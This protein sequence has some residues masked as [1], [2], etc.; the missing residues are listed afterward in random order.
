MDPWA[1]A[2]RQGIAR[3][4]FRVAIEVFAYALLALVLGFAVT[5]FF[6]SFYEGEPWY[7]SLFYILFQYIVNAV[8]IYMVDEA[9][10]RFF[11]VDADSFVGVSVFTNAFLLVQTQLYHRMA[12]L[13]T[14]ITEDEITRPVEIHR[15]PARTSAVPPARACRAPAEQLEEHEYAFVAR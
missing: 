13:Y 12:S 2:S 5:L 10:L 1:I 14:L 9:Y 6:P 3:P 4:L 15:P 7:L 8:V 11:G